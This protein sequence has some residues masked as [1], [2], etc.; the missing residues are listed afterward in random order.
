MYH[1]LIKLIVGASILQLGITITLEDLASRKG[2]D[3]IQ[4][5]SH[6]IIEIDWKPISVFPSEA[7]KFRQ[8]QLRK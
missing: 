7:R 3:R 5:A 2:L 8:A 1:L 6:K 4:S